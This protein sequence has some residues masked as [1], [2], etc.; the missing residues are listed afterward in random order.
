MASYRLRRKLFFSFN[1]LNNFSAM[2]K[3]VN[4]AGDTLSKGQRALEAVK[5]AGKLAGYGTA[6]YTIGA[7]AQG[8]GIASA[9]IQGPS[10][11]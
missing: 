2:A 4:Q 6:A 1:P 10:G 3:G 8:A 9:G 5:G 11:M 7:A